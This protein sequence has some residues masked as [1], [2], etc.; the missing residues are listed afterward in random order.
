MGYTYI[1]VSH[2]NNI[3]DYDVL[4]AQAID[5]AFVRLTYGQEGVDRKGLAHAEKLHKAGVPVG[6]YFYSY[7]TKPEQAL[8]E[9][10]H[11]LLEVNK[12]SFTPELPLVIDMEDADGKKQGMRAEYACE[13]CDIACKRIESA[14]YY[15]MIY[16]NVDWWTRMLTDPNLDK[17]DRWVARWGTKEPHI[18]Y[19]IWQYKA[20]GAICGING[21]VDMSYSDRDYKSFAS[22]KQGLQTFTAGQLV[23]VTSQI[24]YNGVKNAAWVLN[25]T[26]TVLSVNGDRVVIG[27][28]GVVTGAWHAR[29]LN[30]A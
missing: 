29:D 12:L 14:G 3:V 22:R 27:I 8:G 24:D 9:V 7:A 23:N 30:L 4:A 20:D 5:G 6:C 16:A 10:N 25:K 28:N 18:R 15:A 19:G 26:F 2:H 17:Y 1:D 21:N 11:F 13:I